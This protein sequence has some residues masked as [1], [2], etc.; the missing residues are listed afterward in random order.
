M[1]TLATCAALQRMQA[2]PARA[3]SSEPPTRYPVSPDQRDA[4]SLFTLPLLDENGSLF[5]FSDREIVAHDA[6]LLAALARASLL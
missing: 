6:E 2:I 4:I 3:D 5:H 1:G